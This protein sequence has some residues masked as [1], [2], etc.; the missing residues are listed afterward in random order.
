MNYTWYQRTT[1]TTF[2]S[3]YIN[4]ES[5]SNEIDESDL[6]SDLQSE[7]DCEQGI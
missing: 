4:A 6:Q 7:N 1:K 2:D 3:V 5:V